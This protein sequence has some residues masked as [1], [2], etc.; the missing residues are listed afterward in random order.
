MISFTIYCHLK[1]PSETSWF[2]FF[3][4][5]SS[6]PTKVALESIASKG[7]AM[8]VTARLNLSLHLSREIIPST[9]KPTKK[10]LK[11]VQKIWRKKKRQEFSMTDQ[12]P[13][14]RICQVVG[15]PSH[16]SDMELT[17]TSFLHSRF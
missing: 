17:L 10:A 11:K 4:K 13:T 12:L 3:S 2:L 16:A 6:S 8:A 5:A 15:F 14:L 9:K 1:K 7:H